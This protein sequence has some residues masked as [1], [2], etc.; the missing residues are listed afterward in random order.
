MTSGYPDFVTNPTF[1]NEFYQNPFHLLTASERLAIAFSGK[2]KVSFPPGTNWA[3]AHT[4]MVILAQILQLVGHKPLATLLS[5]YVLKPLGL[6]NTVASQT[7]TIPSPVLHAFSSKRRQALQIP[8]A[9]PFYEESSFWNPAWTTA[10]GDVETTNVY[11]MTKTAQG[12]GSGALLSKSSYQ[13]QTGPNLL[14]FGHPQKPPAP[15]CACI[16]QTNSYN[17][18]LGIVRSGSWA[19]GDPELRRLRSGGRLPSVQEGRDRGGHHLRAA[20]V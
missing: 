10:P 14:G 6:T 18:G 5:N 9:I 3:Y 19:V 7:A 16:K 1:I 4:N 8:P 11:D 2:Y 17:Y 12:V 15:A 13:A 20:S